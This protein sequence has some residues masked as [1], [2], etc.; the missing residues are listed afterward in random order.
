LL[1]AATFPL[2]KKSTADYADFTDKKEVLSSPLHIR[3]IRVIRGRILSFCGALY[4]L[5]ESPKIVDCQS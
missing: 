1:T 5:R 3:V 2:E 4:P